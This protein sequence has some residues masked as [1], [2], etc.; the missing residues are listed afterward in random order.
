MWF[1]GVNGFNTVF[2]FQI[3]KPVFLPHKEFISLFPTDRKILLSDTGHMKIVPKYLG[4]YIYEIVS[5]DF[6]HSTQLGPKNRILYGFNALNMKDAVNLLVN[7][8]E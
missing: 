5:T 2:I 1:A 6:P 7:S 3:D 4:K 8:I